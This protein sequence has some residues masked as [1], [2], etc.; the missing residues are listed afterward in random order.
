M[1]KNN[2]IMRAVICGLMTLVSDP[3]YLAA[4]GWIAEGLYEEMSIDCIEAGHSHR[5]DKDHDWKRWGNGSNHASSFLSY[6]SNESQNIGPG[7]FAFLAFTTA[8]TT[9][10]T[11]TP[12]ASGSAPVSTVDTFTVTTSGI[13]LITWNVAITTGNNVNATLDLLINGTGINSPFESMGYGGGGGG[14]ITGAVS[15]SFLVNMNASQTIQLQVSAFVGEISAKI[16][17]AHV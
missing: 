5:H 2:F 9:N 6:Y 12:S 13:Y 14:A 15:G 10:N 1:K 16:G 3:S 4:D 8:Q 17:R 7:T 11:I